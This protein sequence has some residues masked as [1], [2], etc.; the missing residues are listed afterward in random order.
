M[1]RV[2]ELKRDD[3]YK[4]WQAHVRYVGRL[5]IVELAAL[6]GSRPIGQQQ[7]MTPEDWRE[8]PENLH[9]D[10][11][12]Q[13][14]LQTLDRLG[15]L[16]V[17]DGDVLTAK[18]NHIVSACTSGGGGAREA[19]RSMDMF[20]SSFLNRTTN[21]VITPDYSNDWAK[22]VRSYRDYVVSKS[23]PSYA[24]ED[25]VREQGLTPG[26]AYSDPTT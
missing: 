14:Y 20:L 16:I 1:K 23:L 12:F 13:E 21:G 18:H 7:I 22:D 3:L 10:R 15:V 24:S 9:L 4:V 25:E 26:R 11:Y 2:C 5:S 17:N 6:H 8:L 19:T